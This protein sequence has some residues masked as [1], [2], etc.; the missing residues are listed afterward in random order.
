[1]TVAKEDAERIQTSFLNA[2]EKK[3]LVWLAERQPNWMTSDI[4]TWIGTLVD[5]FV[6]WMLS[7]HVFTDGFWGEYIVSPVISFQ[8]AVAVNYVISYFF[9]WKDR[10]RDRPDASVGR[11]FR[12]YLKYNLTNSTVFLLRLGLLLLVERFT[13][14]DVV[15]CNLTAMLFSGILNF[16]IDNLLIFRKR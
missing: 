13:G 4:L 16:I 2:N 14:W 8:C 3:V 10:T 9:V 7:D 5:T 1:M 15:I 6:L 11:F 12:L